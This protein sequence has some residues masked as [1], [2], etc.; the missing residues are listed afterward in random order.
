L[1][2]RLDLQQELLRKSEMP[3]SFSVHAAEVTEGVSSDARFNVTAL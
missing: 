1:L 3:E 2:A